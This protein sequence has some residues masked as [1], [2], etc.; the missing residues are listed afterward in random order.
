MSTH[1]DDTDRGSVIPGIQAIFREELLSGAHDEE[2]PCVHLAKTV[3]TS[4][5]LAKSPASASR[6]PSSIS[7]ICHRWSPASERTPS[8]RSAYLHMAHLYL[9][10]VVGQHLS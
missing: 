7:L 8:A 3:T 9:P 5:S 6:R 1:R 10:D 4:S 2:G